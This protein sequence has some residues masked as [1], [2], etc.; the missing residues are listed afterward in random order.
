MAT[1]SFHGQTTAAVGT[2]SGQVIKNKPGRIAN[3]L[4]T[5]ATSGLVVYDGAQVVYGSQ[6]SLPVATF[7]ALDIP[8]RTSIVV[9]LVSGS[10][11][12]SYS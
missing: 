3:L 10:L 12:L 7:V 5:G 1:E 9:D 8:C 6:A 11:T 2:G 4:V